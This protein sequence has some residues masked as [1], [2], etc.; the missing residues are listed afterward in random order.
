MQLK[1]TKEIH[2]EVCADSVESALIAQNAGAYRIELCNNLIEGGTTPSYGTIE[3]AR[4]L[5]TIKLYV[6]IRPRGG[7]FLYD[8]L[9]FETM[10]SDIELCG[11]LGCDGVVIGL[12]LPDGTIDK[13]RCQELITIAH[14]Y[15]MGVTF[16]RAFDRCNN[17]FDVMETIID[18][19]CE[20]ILTS[21]GKNTALEGTET[22]RQL[23]E[24]AQGRISIMLGAGITPE[25]I[26]EL[27]QKTNASEFHGTFRSQYPSKME[28]RNTSLGD[29]QEEYMLWKTD[30][31]KIR[32]IQLI[33]NVI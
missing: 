9:E 29:F 27:L 23:I 4:K 18:L 25:N 2:L 28:Y 10:K 30:E 7:D 22:I 12:L 24:K 20:R 11:K 21:G 15:N 5:L 26:G 14:Q 17:F 8:D 33:I 31:G 13:I 19:G 16:H 1:N 6:L 3:Q 32:K